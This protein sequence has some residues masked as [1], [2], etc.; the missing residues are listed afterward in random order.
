MLM[1]GEEIRVETVPHGLRPGCFG[2]RM[3]A[4]TA[5]KARAIDKNA[6]GNIL[7]YSNTQTNTPAQVWVCGIGR[8]NENTLFIIVPSNII[9]RAATSNIASLI[10]DDEDENRKAGRAADAKIP[11]LMPNGLS[12]ALVG[13]QRIGIK[14]EMLLAGVARVKYSSLEKGR[15]MTRSTM[16]EKLAKEWLESFSAVDA[17]QSK[18]TGETNGG[19]YDYE[20]SRGRQAQSHYNADIHL[21]FQNGEAANIEVKNQFARMICPKNART[22]FGLE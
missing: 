5:R 10:W 18:W 16:A 15:N 17:S 8:K 2:G 14:T 3:N 13:L 20:N 19:G 4:E 6:V 11:R 12:T 1:N 9:R 21:V 7:G 22:E